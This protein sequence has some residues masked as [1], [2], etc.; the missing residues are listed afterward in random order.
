[1]SHRPSIVTDESSAIIRPF[2]L[3]TPLNTPIDAGHLHLIMVERPQTKIFKAAA[4]K[5]RHPLLDR[6]TLKHEWAGT[7]VEASELV[8]ISVSASKWI[9]L[10]SAASHSTGS[11]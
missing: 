6:K 10:F 4:W 5:T 3:P 9:C 1:L 11:L 2:F 7:K 8:Q